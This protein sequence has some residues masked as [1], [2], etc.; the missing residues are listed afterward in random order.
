[1]KTVCKLNDLKKLA[2]VLLVCI[3]ATSCFT[4]DDGVISDDEL[5]EL[6]IKVTNCPLE[7][8]VMTPVVKVLGTPGRWFVQVTVAITCMGEPVNEAELKVKY[9]WIER[10]V[11]IETNV[12]GNATSRQRVTSTAR[13]SGK[14]TVT[15]E[16]SDGSRPMTVN[17]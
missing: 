4:D 12:S 9:G 2:L 14:V 6:T 17:F 7:N 11:K 16:G 1:M 5:P 3:T 10:A 15:V 13:P 8:L